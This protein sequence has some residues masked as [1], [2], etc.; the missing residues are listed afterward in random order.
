MI[1]VIVNFMIW[2]FLFLKVFLLVADK[3]IQIKASFQVNQWMQRSFNFS[4]FIRDQHILDK[5]GKDALYYILF[6][7]YLIIFLT[8][9]TVL[10][11]SIILPINYSGDVRKY[12]ILF[13]FIR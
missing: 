10:S 8:I 5:C 13:A 2:I 11:I 4:Y 3:H 6:Q 1:T 7:R 12:T 9:V